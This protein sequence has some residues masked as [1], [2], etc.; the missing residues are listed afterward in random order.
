MSK[1]YKFKK[2]RKSLNP[3]IVFAMFAI[4]LIF[5]STGYALLSDT[6]TIN[7]KATFLDSSGGS[8]YEIGNSTYTVGDNGF[9][10]N[11][12]GLYVYGVQINV[13]NLD[14]TYTDHLEIAFDVP[15]GFYYDEGYMYNVWQAQSITFVNNRVTILFQSYCSYLALEETVTIWPQLSFYSET[16]LTITNLTL[17]G[18]LATCTSALLEY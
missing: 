14:D 7:G 10:T 13:T 11:P 18:K 1:K 9:W 16:D 4:C 8:D 6:L 3:Y 15:E 2:R 17:N 5:V 12:D